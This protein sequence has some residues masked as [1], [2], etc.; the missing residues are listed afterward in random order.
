M[1]AGVF[2]VVFALV[3]LF[4]GAAAVV[5][6]AE[7]A[8]D[9]GLVSRVE[10]TE[11]TVFDAADPSLLLLLLL[12]LLLMPLLTAAPDEEDPGFSREDLVGV[13]E[14]RISGSTTV[15]S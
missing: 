4:A 12:L 10:A 7:I 11:D 6:A 3:A 1:F 8:E 9:G 5:A 13:G 2:A 15:A 14:S